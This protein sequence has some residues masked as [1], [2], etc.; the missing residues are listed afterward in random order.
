[1]KHPVIVVV[2]VSL[3]LTATAAWGQARTYPDGHGGEVTFPQ[4]EVSFADEVVSHDTGSK[5][6]ADH[7]RDPEAALGIPDYSND[8]GYTS[9]GCGGTL[10]LKFTDNALV[11][12]PGPDLYVF[13]IGPDVEPTALAISADGEAWTRV[14][15]IEGGKAEVDIAPYTEPGAT[16][17]FVKLVDLGAH[18]GSDT[19]GADIDAVGAIGSARRIALSGKVLF[20]SGK[21]QLKTAAT[22]AIVTALA[23][24]DPKAVQSVEVA[25]Y[26]DS[27]GDDKAN[28]V[29]SENRAKAV[30]GYLVEKAGFPAGKV[31]TIGHGESQPVADNNTAAG[32]AQNRRVEITVRSLQTDAPANTQAR[33]TILGLWDAGS[34]GTVELSEADGKIQGTYTEDNGRVRGQFSSE[35]VIDGYWIEDGSKKACDTEKDGSKHWGALQITFKS[36]AHDEFDAKWRYCGEEDWHGAWPHATRVL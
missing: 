1:M 18:C 29:L 31:A 36:K 20:D 26:T 28:Q 14:G 16:F 22:D 2:L 23:D 30:A 4:G 15:R 11:D 12:V 3:A 32:R 35:N 6:P 21:Y 19:P 27:V 17:R 24:V 5:K 8:R 34:I 10:V 25:G 9:L 33:V 7:A 13:E